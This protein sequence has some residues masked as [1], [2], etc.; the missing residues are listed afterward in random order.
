MPAQR[1]Y[2]DHNATGPMH[3]EAVAAMTPY[4]A[5]AFGNPSAPYSVGQD[6]R[7][8]IANA[9]IQVAGLLGA[10][11]DHV[12]FASGGTEA[13]NL[14]IA[15]AF[16]GRVDTS[17]R[18]L[19]LSAIEHPSVRETCSWLE[20]KH[21]AQIT[22]VGVGCDGRVRADEVE[23]AL[24]PETLLVS[25]MHANNETGVIQPVE[26]IGQLL[27]P[28]GVRFHVDGV[29]AAGRVPVDLAAVGCS[30]YA[31]SAHKFGGMK[32]TGALVL[33]DRADM[34]AISHGGHQE[35]GWRAGTENVPGIVAMGAAAEAAQRDLARNHAH[36]LRMREVF[37]GLAARLSQCWRNGHPKHRLP[38]TTSLCCFHADA[39]SVVMA[40]DSQGISVGTGS[41]C[42]SMIQEPSRVLLAMGLDEQAAFCTIRVSTGPENTVE[43]ANWVAGKIMETVDRVRMVTAPET[44]GTCGD[45][46]P[47]HLK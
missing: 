35:D 37:D 21:G 43:E 3:P 46:C 24:R 17:R 26:E 13:N 19:I 40:L 15:G 9:R 10:S 11:A 12:V 42:A 38:N 34:G 47:C 31:I 32:G 2:L 20:A 1:V 45:N 5:Q 6:A 18:H 23:R 28:L 16:F 41:A 8:A 4:L 33:V 39:M 29:Q 44:I 30:S 7:R 27:R 36:C 25:V 22:V 14:A